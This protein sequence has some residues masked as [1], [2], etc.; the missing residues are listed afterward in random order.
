ME[1]LL[2]F[3]TAYYKEG[4]FN[5]LLYQLGM[6]HTDRRHISKHYLSSNFWWDL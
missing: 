6:M 4:S 3:N 1:I 5:L 2:N